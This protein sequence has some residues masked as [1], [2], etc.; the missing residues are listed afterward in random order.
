MARKTFPI[1]TLREHPAV[2]IAAD[3]PCE[4]TMVAGVD[5]I[6]SHF[7]SRNTETAPNLSCNQSQSDRGL[8]AAAVRSCYDDAFDKPLLLS[9][10][11]QWMGIALVP[12]QFMYKRSFIH[13]AVPF[14]QHRLPEFGLTSTHV[15]GDKKK[16]TGPWSIELLCPE[17]I[18]NPQAFALEVFFWKPQ[19]NREKEDEVWRLHNQVSKQ[20][21]P[22]SNRRIPHGRNGPAGVRRAL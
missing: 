2:E 10:K 12:D 20:F 15:T 19:R 21:L 14:W 4:T 9:P 13:Q 18:V 8:A 1:V 5:E 6:R 22:A 3:G 11:I 16:T 7:E 17:E